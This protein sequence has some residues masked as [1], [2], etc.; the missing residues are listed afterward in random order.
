MSK[1]KFFLALQAQ[2]PPPLVIE[3]HPGTPLPSIIS[4]AALPPF[5]HFLSSSYLQICPT[6]FATPT[7]NPMGPISKSLLFSPWW[8]HSLHI[9]K[10]LQAVLFLEPY[11]LLPWRMVISYPFS[12]SLCSHLFFALENLPGNTHVVC[13]CA[14]VSIDDESS[15]DSFVWLGKPPR[16]RRVKK[17]ECSIPKCKAL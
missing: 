8:H 6:I 17:I 10:T 15:W 14:R 11:Q 1:Y 13:C 9:L 4:P 2:P 5:L 16:D 7:M 3:K 12:L